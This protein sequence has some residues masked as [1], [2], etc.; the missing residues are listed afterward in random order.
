MIQQLDHRV[1]DVAGH[2][3]VTTDIRIAADGCH[4]PCPGTWHT[5][6]FEV[7]MAAGR[8]R[9]VFLGQHGALGVLH[10]GTLQSVQVGGACVSAASESSVDA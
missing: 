8:V 3:R 10:Q 6:R 4:G 2:G 7:F 9:F 1:N 5:V